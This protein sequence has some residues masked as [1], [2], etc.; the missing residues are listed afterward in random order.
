MDGKLVVTARNGNRF[1]FE[2][3][4]RN[5]V[6]LLSKIQR[7]VASSHGGYGDVIFEK[8]YGT[9]EFFVVQR[10]CEKVRVQVPY[11]PGRR[12]LYLVQ[13]RNRE[14]KRSPALC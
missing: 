2:I 14:T 10:S 6:V 3:N 7:C 11:S 5:L 12:C 8:T 4:D 1:L 9:C 13:L